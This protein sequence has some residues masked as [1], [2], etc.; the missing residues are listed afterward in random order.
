MKAQS[1]SND[2]LSD[3]DLLILCALADDIHDRTRCGQP[4]NAAEGKF[5]RLMRQRDL[6]EPKK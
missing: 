4:A 3:S 5:L 2:G 1:P 6:W